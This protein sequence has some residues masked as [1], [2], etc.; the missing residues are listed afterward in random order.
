M[1]VELTAL[2]VMSREPQNLGLKRKQVIKKRSHQGKQVEERIVKLEGR[3]L[4]QT[5]FFGT[6]R[7]FEG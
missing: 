3:I 2:S 5:P 6:S 1:K 4:L 7:S